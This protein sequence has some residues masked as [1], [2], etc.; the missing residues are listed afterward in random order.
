MR[1]AAQAA[2]AAEAEASAAPSGHQAREA[3]DHRRQVRPAAVRLHR[4]ERQERRLRRRDRALV[5]SLCVRQGEPRHFACATTPAREPSLTTAASISSSPR[6]RTTA[7]AT[8]GSTSRGR[9][10]RR[11]GACSCGTTRRSARSPTS[12]AGGSR[13]RAARSTT[14][15]S[16]LLHGHGPEV[17]R[18]PSRTRVLAFHRRPRGHADVGRHRA[19][20]A[21]PRTIAS[22]SSRR[23]LPLLCPTAS[24]SAGLHGR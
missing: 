9:T 16:R 20:S 3:V 1:R 15:G 4:R 12:P 7:T 21:S 17:D 24:A 22:S 19:R 14:G 5:R 2:F 10:T 6:S 23:P 18:Q 11:P 8:R 13:R